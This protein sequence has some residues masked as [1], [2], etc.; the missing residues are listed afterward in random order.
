MNKTIVGSIIVILIILAGG[1][2]LV[3]KASNTDKILGSVAQSGE[4]QSTTTKTADVG[5]HQYGTVAAGTASVLGSVVI[6][7]THASVVEIRD[8][9]STTD[10]ASTSIA[11]LAASPS[12][13][14]TFDVALKRGLS[15]YSQAGFTGIYTITFR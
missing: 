5:L 4:Y 6:G 8:A 1:Y 3:P 15:V 9:T 14:Y 13:T 7:T 10:V 11:T 12:G 2:F